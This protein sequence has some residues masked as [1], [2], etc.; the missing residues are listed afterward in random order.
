MKKVFSGIKY[1]LL[2]GT[3]VSLAACNDNGQSSS[4]GTNAETNEGKNA[5]VSNSGTG[6]SDDAAGAINGSGFPIVNKPITLSAMVQLSPAQ[7]TEWN[8]IMAWQEYEKM[9]GIHIE[10]DEYTAADMTE[11]RNLALASDQLPDIFY[12]TKMPDN[13]VDKYGADG[14]FLKLNDLIDKYAPNFKAVME[15][16]PDVKKGIATADGSIYAL[17]NL[18]D[19]P[20]IEI[21]KKLFLNQSWLKKT[22]KSMPATT[23]ELYNVLKAFRD[24]DPNGN[25]KHDEVPLTADSLDDIMLVL[26]G[27][28]GL[29]DKGTGNGS[30][31]VDP[32]SGEMRYFPASESYKQLLDY[33][34]RLYSENLIDKEIFTNDGTKVLAKNEQNQI[35]SFSFSNVIARANTNANDFA[36]LD[37]ALAGPNGDRL[38]T[39]ARGHIGSRGA[40]MI[41]KTNPYPAATMRWIDYFYGEDGI[42]MLYLGLEGKTYQKN[43]DGNYDFLPAIVGNIPEGSSFDQVVSKYVPYAGGSLPTLI[44]ENYFKGGETEPSAKAA[45][46]HLRPFLPA[47]LWAPFSFTAE[48]AADK[49][50]LESDIYGLV[51]QRTAEFVQGKA[52]L[53]DFDKYVDQ[54][55]KMG[56]DDLQ[57]IYQTAYERYKAN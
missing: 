33:L 50:T 23:D 13:D 18:T 21:T 41:S 24:G 48:E 57:R 12:R 51:K 20:S 4:D 27:A 1:I 30:W 3:V 38:F 55:K 14:S 52:S 25:G 5:S 34:H 22:G 28:F 40:F 36:G 45:A 53:G 35:G 49:Q 9:T 42:R 15:K 39:S 7:P 56:L 2:L 17:P 44:L 10:W 19:S 16:Y 26:Q 11:K 43:A 6:N 8:D 31:D 47:E 54:L 37:K 32:G 29:G 46:E